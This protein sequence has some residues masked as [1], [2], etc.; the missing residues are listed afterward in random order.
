MRP[1]KMSPDL[2]RTTFSLAHAAPHP[3]SS[4]TS[5]SSCSSSANKPHSHNGCQSPS[6]ATASGTTGGRAQPARQ[7]GRTRPG[8]RRSSRGRCPVPTRA[9]RARTVDQG[10]IRRLRSPPVREV[11]GGSGRA[12]PARPGLGRAPSAAG[13]GRRWDSG[14]P[15]RERGR[16]PASRPWVQCVRSCRS[17]RWQRRRRAR[18]RHGGG[19]QAQCR[20][21]PWS[22]WSSLPPSAPDSSHARVR[23][24]HLAA[25][26]AQSPQYRCSCQG[27]P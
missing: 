1:L 15:R 2:H 21:S 25:P 12:G 9:P 26:L 22:I 14:R 6:R 7:P 27:S 4:T 10:E 19:R 23:V 18:T 17:A 13:P 3:T 5:D 16:R 24:R 11:A 20:R 8:P